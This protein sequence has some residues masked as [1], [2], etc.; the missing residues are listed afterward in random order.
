MTS[1]E[2]KLLNDALQRLGE[3]VESV[4]RRV[5]QYRSEVAN[6]VPKGTELMF[7]SREVALLEAVQRILGAL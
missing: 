3:L 4:D 7:A 6:G 1:D 2:H 5:E